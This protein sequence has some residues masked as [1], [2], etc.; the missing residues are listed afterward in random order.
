MAKSRYNIDRL[1]KKFKEFEDIAKSDIKLILSESANNIVNGAKKNVRSQRIWNYGKLW[2]S[3]GHE[4]KDDG[5]RQV[6]FVGEEYAPFIEFG[7]GPRVEIPTG[8]QDLASQFIGGKHLKNKGNFDQFLENILQWVLHKKIAT[9][10][11]AKSV[12]YLIA[13][14]L[15]KKGQKARPFLIPAFIEERPKIPEKIDKILQRS[16]REFNKD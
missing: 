6:I 5:F 4:S 10:K 12:A 11:Q 15:L 16:A 13:M 8:F 14:S 9:P 7:S 3:I 2:Q 1:R